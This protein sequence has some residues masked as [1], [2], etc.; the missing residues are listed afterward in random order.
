MISF[1]RYLA[2]QK[3]T[4]GNLKRMIGARPS[5][6]VT[7]PFQGGEIKTPGA[8]TGLQSYRREARPEVSV[9]GFIPGTRR[10]TTLKPRE[11]SSQAMERL[12]RGKSKAAAAFGL[13]TFEAAR[14]ARN[15]HQDVKDYVQSMYPGQEVSGIDT[16]KILAKGG[17]PPIKTMATSSDVVPSVAGGLAKAAETAL[18]PATTVALR[19]PSAKAME[20]AVRRA[21]NRADP[22][23]ERKL[24]ASPE[25]AKY[26]T[27]LQYEIVRRFEPDFKK[28]QAGKLTVSDMPDTETVVTGSQGLFGTKP[29][30][31]TGTGSLGSLLKK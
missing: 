18:A 23:G 6:A 4:I 5:M 12:D 27:K 16:A 25:G 24:A 10:T 8:P 11:T 30:D 26:L 19:E 15:V 20:D 3:L 29:T 1:S 7:R 21:M 28:R 9:P 13:S 31:E 2:E 22:T 14:T 17:I